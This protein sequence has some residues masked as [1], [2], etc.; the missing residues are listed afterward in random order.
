MR[1]LRLAWH[2]VPWVLVCL[3]VAQV[4]PSRVHLSET[5]HALSRISAELNQLRIDQSIPTQVLKQHRNSI[6]YIYLVYTFD[7]PG[8]G[9]YYQSLRHIRVSGT[10]FI[11]A[12]GVV[13]TN[14]HVL[15]PWFED[16]EDATLIRAGLHPRVEKILA[17]FPD[18]RD[19]IPLHDVSVSRDTDLA[20][21]HFV[22]P[23]DGDFHPIP[24]ANSDATAGDPV[25]VVGYPLG[26]SAMLAKSPP[27]LYKRLA[28]SRDTIAVANELAAHS[29]I[30]PSAT[31]GHLGDVVGEKL[32]YDAP[33]AQGGSGGPV[34][35][36][37][38]Q[39]IAINAAYIDGF[40]GGTIGI[41]VQKLK[42]LLF[43]K[44]APAALDTNVAANSDGLVHHSSAIAP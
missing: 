41:T 8:G 24:L 11:A 13:A 32:I 18:R 29:L 1:V 34:F 31:Y 33:T 16:D 9:S 20:V 22:A 19:P 23:K 12:D 42:P 3:L 26:V 39:V 25:V 44:P 10:G 14:R 4:Y 28:S 15:Q 2:L 38:G 43:G 35:N 5:D 17:F 6:C 36:G 7:P 37:R 21:A 30:R 40:T 27:K